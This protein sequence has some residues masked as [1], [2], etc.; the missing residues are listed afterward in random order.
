MPPTPP[1]RAHVSYLELEWVS[2]PPRRHAVS[3][4]L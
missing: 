1:D 2:A 3:E 4:K